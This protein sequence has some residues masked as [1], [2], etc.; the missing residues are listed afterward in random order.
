LSGQRGTALAV[1]LALA[2]V[3]SAACAG[4][5]SEAGLAPRQVIEVMAVWT[6]VEQQ[7]FARVVTDFE[8][9]TGYSVTHTSASAGVP[10]ALAVRVAHGRP[11]DVAFLPQPGV[12]RQYATQSLLV[13]LDRLAQAA[14]AR[15]YSPVWRDL[16]S[17][18]GRLYG[19]WFKAANKSLIWYNIGAFERAGV[20]PPDSI[21]RLLTVA[22]TLSASGVPAF[23]VGGG[24]R[25]TLTDWFENLYLRVA[26]PARYD[27]LASHRL[28]WTDETVKQ[29]LR[30]LSQ[31]WAPSLLAG[32]TKGALATTFTESVKQLFAT[33]PAAATT[34]A[35][36]KLVKRGSG[37]R[38]QPHC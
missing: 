29:T 1:A 35:L 31:L 19:V 36:S 23:A 7:R 22:E 28:A 14:V 25:W 8:T 11:P 3:A 16:G 21:G 6:D 12:L 24:N 9:R 32:G 18:G 30:L 4:P 10:Q 15:N 37:A 27:Q 2:L 33:P 26:G 38:D 17:V 5:G 13:P 20:V 34:W